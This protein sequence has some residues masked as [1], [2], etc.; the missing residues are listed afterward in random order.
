[1]GEF[2]LTDNRTAIADGASVGILISIPTGNELIMGV[3]ADVPVEFAVNV[4]EDPTVTDNGVEITPIDIDRAAATVPN[5]SFYRDPT[6]SDD[7]D[8]L[9][10]RRADQGAI[11]EAIPKDPGKGGPMVMKENEEYV[12]WITN[13]SGAAANAAIVLSFT[14]V[15]TRAL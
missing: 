15:P 3:D 8:L 7:G 10:S 9:V 5:S 6:V 14:E 2:L 13:R 12:V 1:M 11:F 4:Y